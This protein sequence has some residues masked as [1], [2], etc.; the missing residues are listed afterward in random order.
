MFSVNR[1]WQSNNNQTPKLILTHI[2]ICAG[3]IVSI[4]IDQISFVIRRE[5]LK[6]AWWGHKIETFCAL[7]AICAG[8]S[9]VTGEFTPQRPV[10]RSFDVFFHLCLNE[11]LSKQS[12]GWWFETPWRSFYDVIV[13][14]VLLLYVV[15]QLSLTSSGSGGIYEFCCQQ[16]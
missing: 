9:P 12:W 2:T 4:S 5:T 6:A 13:M 10:T 8:N 14:C 3:A 16:D 7:L 1:R 11:R 15:G